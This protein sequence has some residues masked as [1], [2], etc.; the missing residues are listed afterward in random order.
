MPSREK[1]FGLHDEGVAVPDVALI[2]LP[3]DGSVSFRTGS[4]AAPAR[5]R[6]LSRTADPV[7]RRGRR[8]A[9]TVRDFG[10]VAT[11]GP[12]GRELS[13]ERF[14]ES[15]FARLQAL[16]AESFL[17]ALGGDNSVSVPV[18]R[19]FA[20]RNAGDVGVVWFD[21]HPDLFETYDGAADSHA[22]AL[23]RAMDRCGL[24][25]GQVTLI[26]TRSFS[27][28]ELRFIESAKLDCI[29]AADWAD[30]SAA[31]VVDRIA[32]RLGGRRA[33]YLA[34]DV[35]GFDA[36]CAPGTGYPLPGGVAAEPFFRFQEELF[37]RLPVRA[38]DLTEIAP[39][40]DTNDVTSFL[41]VQIVL[42]TLA[43]L[44]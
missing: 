22:C 21:A 44:G 37:R 6:E 40:L 31:A 38:M 9:V 35:D 2:G 39:P 12:D 26:G 41:G 10:D 1:W 13:P 32:G 5:L 25:P 15:A 18:L 43:L 4:A 7:S 11:T 34:V 24:D 27:T 33:I 19:A 23:R 20:E 16:P 36:A 42:E 30:G 3:F 17:L 14:L 29:T 28:G 8:T